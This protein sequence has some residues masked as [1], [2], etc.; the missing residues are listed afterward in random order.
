MSKI[1]KRMVKELIHHFN[2]SPRI[3]LAD[4]LALTTRYCE[5]LGEREAFNF[6]NFCYQENTVSG[7]S[8]RAK[9]TR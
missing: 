2:L 1:E 8:P 3:V 5:P 9:D 6:L 4:W 7:D